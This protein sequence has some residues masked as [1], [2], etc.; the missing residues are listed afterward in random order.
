MNFEPYPFEKL[1]NLLKNITPNPNFT[2]STLTIGEPQRDTPAFIQDKLCKDSALLRKYPKTS[3]EK[4]LRDAQRLFVEKRFGVELKDEEII[5]TFGTREVLFNFPQFLLFDK[6]EPAIAF[7]N[8][9]YQIYEGAAIASRAKIVHINMN[10]A[11]DF[12]P[13]IDENALSKCNLVIINSPNNPTASTLSLD[14]LVEWVKLSQKHNFTLINDECYSELYIDEKTPSLLE[15]AIVA[16]NSE[17]KNILVVN[18]ISK[19]SSAP[20]L[21]S[22]FIA[23]DAEILKEYMKYRT[24]IGCASPLPLQ[25]AAALAWSDE[26]HVDV[27][28]EMYKENF[29]IANEILGTK[30]PKATFYLWLKVKKPQ[31]FTKNLYK[32]YNVKVLPGEYLARKNSDGINPAKE[33]IRVALVESPSMI[34]DALNRIKECLT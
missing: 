32:K 5:P 6:K 23:G 14:E 9:F 16:N 25:G 7:T 12:K 30:I 20:G 2:P 3:G 1:N 17:F 34:R 24:Y 27:A 33:Y 10:E 11:N 4:Q 13:E 28:R 31:E 29:K 8:P 26:E 22:G 18:S 21:R 19:R 15:A